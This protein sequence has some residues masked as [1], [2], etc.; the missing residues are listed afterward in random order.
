MLRKIMIVFLTSASFMHAKMHHHEIISDKITANSYCWENV[1]GHF[2][3]LLI[4]WNALRPQQGYYAIYVSVKTE[5]WSPWLLYA[6]WGKDFQMGCSS[7]ESSGKVYVHQDAVNLINDLT[8]TGFKIKIV[9]EEGAEVQNFHSLHVCSSIINEIT[10]KP[11]TKP[12]KSTTLNVEGISQMALDDARRERLCSPTSTTAV[13]RFLQE[14]RTAQPIDFAEKSWDQGFDIFGN[15]VFNVVEAYHRL[16]TGKYHCWVERCESFDTVF[17]TL[18]KGLPCV[19]SIRGPLEGS[20]L[21]Y[22]SGHLLAVIGYDCETNE[23]LCMDP[24]FPN[25]E[26]TKVRYPLDDLITAWS[27]RKNVAY[28]FSAHNK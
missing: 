25:D 18:E 10:T 12:T 16:P 28:V 14:K 9:G 1:E 15:W 23:V 6:Q 4:S 22:S 26:S 11:Y 7:K 17:K 27:R 5:E 19:I 8:A 20:A 13:V 3:E 24:A 21:P 2:N